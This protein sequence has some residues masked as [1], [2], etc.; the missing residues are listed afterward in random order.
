MSFS[1]EVKKKKK[2]KHMHIFIVY[3]VNKDWF[4]GIWYYT[5]FFSFFF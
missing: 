4:Y 5:D 3:I 2:G 1:E